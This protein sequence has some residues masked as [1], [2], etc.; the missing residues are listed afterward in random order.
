MTPT[1]FFIESHGVAA[2]YLLNKHGIAEGEEAVVFSHRS[3]V[4]VHDGFPAAECGYQHQKG[5][6]GQVEVGDEGVH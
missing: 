1:A 5:A 2:G 3:L 4:G 6:L